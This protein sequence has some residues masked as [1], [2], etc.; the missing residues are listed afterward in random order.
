MDNQNPSVPEPPAKP[1]A[2]SEPLK[3][4]PPIASEHKTPP[5]G[6]GEKP[7]GYQPKRRPPEEPYFVS[8]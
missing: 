7:R 1:G 2:P 5:P 8:Q 3:A 4:P 6:P